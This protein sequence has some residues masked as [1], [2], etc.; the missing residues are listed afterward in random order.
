MCFS[1]V[2]LKTGETVPCG[3]CLECLSRRRNDWSVRLQLHCSMYDRMP[4]FVTLTY[5][6]EDVPLS[7]TSQMTLNPKD[8]QDF[9]KRL[10]N[11]FVLKDTDFSYFGCGEYGDQF[12]RPH[13]H[14]IIFGFDKLAE[15]FDKSAILAE[16]VLEKIWTHG[17][18]DVCV[19]DYGGIHYT[20]KYVLKS[21]E[22]YFPGVVKPFVFASKGIGKSWLSSDECAALKKRFNKDAFNAICDQ[23]PE[24]DWSTP[25]TIESSSAQILRQLQPYVMSFKVS[26]LEGEVVPLPRYYRKQI[27]GS[28]EDWRMNPLS[29]YNYVKSLHKR[30]KYL[31]A[32]GSY[33]AQS[34]KTMEQQRQQERERI[35][36]QRVI[37]KVK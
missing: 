5:K 17:H 32:F 10:R 21:Q 1:P 36:R 25:Q 29:Y 4:F 33:D 35:I 27:F 15:I 28:F 31:N 9:I 24:I 19:A 16:D 2:Q 23:L 20:T 14:M 26:T 8:I 18:V 13:Y 12:G 7:T 6:D 37:N 22:D 30:Y 11:K 34:V 3:H